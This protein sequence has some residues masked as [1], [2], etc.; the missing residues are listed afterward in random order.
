MNFPM[1]VAASLAFVAFSV[2]AQPSGRTAAA[3]SETATGTL[4]R[5]IPSDAMG[6]CNDGMFTKAGRKATA[7]ANHGGLQ[8]WYSDNNA[9]SPTG[10]P[11][12]R[13]SSDSDMAVGEP[14]R[15]IP[16]DATAKCKD[17]SFS[18]AGKRDNACKQHGGVTIWYPGS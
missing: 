6:R 12:A 7:C 16:S 4:V 14:V 13:V 18:K 9:G 1:T 2:T 3:D 10:A 17:G 15:G 11:P 5:G 8:I